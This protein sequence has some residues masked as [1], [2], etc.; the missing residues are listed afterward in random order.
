MRKICMSGS[1][2]GV[3]KRSQGR[4]TEAP[5]DERGDTLLPFRFATSAIFAAPLVNKFGERSMSATVRPA[6]CPEYGIALATLDDDPGVRPEWH[7]LVG[8]KAACFEI[9]DGY[10]SPLLRRF[11]CRRSG[12]S[13]SDQHLNSL[14]NRPPDASSA[15]RA[16]TSWRTACRAASGSIRI[17]AGWS[18]CRPRSAPNSRRSYQGKG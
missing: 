2:S 15:S 6:G 9:T 5:P 10:V 13:A 3:W 18:R 14:R 8:G 12:A 11:S 16:L 4:T 1:M 7:I 17:S